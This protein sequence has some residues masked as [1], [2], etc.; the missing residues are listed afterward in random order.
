MPQNIYLDITI[1]FQTFP[2]AK[3]DRGGGGEWRP[4]NMA[5]I[6]VSDTS[7]T[8]YM[9]KIV[10]TIVSRAMKHIFRH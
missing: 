1:R 9:W 8:K 6:L 5:A 7:N 2:E 4:Y 3:K 10:E